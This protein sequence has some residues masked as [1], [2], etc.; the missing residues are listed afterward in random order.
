MRQTRIDETFLGA[1]DVPFTLTQTDLLASQLAHKLTCTMKRRVAEEYVVAPDNV[2]PGLSGLNGTVELIS[3]N[4][5]KRRALT[6]SADASKSNA[7]L[8]GKAY[9]IDGSLFQ[10]WITVTPKDERDDVTPLSASAYIVLPEEQ[11]LA[12]TVPQVKQFTTRPAPAKPATI[13]IP[14]AG[15][16]AL[17]G[18][19]RITAPRSPE[20]CNNVEPGFQT[21]SYMAGRGRC[22][23]LQAEARS[24]AIVFFLEHQA[25]LGLVRLAERDCR[26]RSTARIARDGETL[27]FPIA[28]TTT[29]P[30]NWS[31]TFE[32]QLEPEL[33]TYYAVVVTNSEIARR[34][35]NHI[36]N[37]PIR[38]SEA[39]RPGLADDQL[40]DWLSD[41]AMLT[42]R[43]SSHIDW[44]A[45]RVKD[46]L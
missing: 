42:A 39:V 46:V 4:L 35:A 31:E 20:D 36:D 45:I 23:L 43:S 6:I 29:A 9:P 44:R 2:E 7:V 11:Q 30:G 25:N 37:L 14:N 5:A 18:P 8:S 27:M 1:R 28:M 17:I 3:N 21:A 38:C 13:S 12:R 33:D 32:W 10:Y 22:S 26:E 40:E 41:F 16:D 15:K 24:D 34:V 19:L